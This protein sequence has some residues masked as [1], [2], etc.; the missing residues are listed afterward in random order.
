ML[1]AYKKNKTLKSLEAQLPKDAVEVKHA[2]I[3]FLEDQPFNALA[4]SM[5]AR[6]RALY[7]KA[8]AHWKNYDAFLSPLK[9][10]LGKYD[11][12]PGS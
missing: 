1:D 10:A 4:L 6:C 11:L 3:N 2:L 7:T 12:S 5:L 9:Q 8:L